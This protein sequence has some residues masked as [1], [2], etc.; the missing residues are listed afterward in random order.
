MIDTEK[1]T[2]ALLSSA[3]SPIALEEGAALVE[4]YVNQWSNEPQEIL[5]VECGWSVQLDE[6]TFA[7]GV[8]DLIAG[9]DKGVFGRELKTTAGASRYWNSDK[10]LADI[11]AGH[12]IALYALAL[13]R[14]VFYENGQ[15]LTM[16]VATPVRMNVRAITKSAIPEFWPKDPA[17]G[18]SEFD[19]LSLNSVVD[20]FRVKAAQIRL[21]RQMKLTPW[22]LRGKQCIAFNKTCEFFDACGSFSNP[23]VEVGFD[24]SDPA[25]KLA[26]PFLPDVAKHPDCVILSASAYGTFSR[27]L[28]L[29]RLEAQSGNKQESLALSIGTVFHAGCAEMHRQIKECP[30]STDKQLIIP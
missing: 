6:Y 12:Q 24:S 27:C 1:I 25:A 3:T 2:D 26:I 7:V 8:M 13:N 23:P 15:P 14:G 10:W 22:Q 18:W 29:G 28:E 17:D 4:A 9:D 19:E 20:A 16:R 21:A 30:S 5:A 11:Q